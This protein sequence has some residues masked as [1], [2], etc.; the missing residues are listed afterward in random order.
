MGRAIAAALGLSGS[1]RHF[2][3]GREADGNLLCVTWCIGHLVQAAEPDAYDP[4]LKSWRLG[5]LPFL[6]EQFRYEAASSTGD[7][8]Q[9]VRELLQ[10]EDVTD[11]V[12]ATDAGRE[13]QLIFHLVYDLAGCARPVQRLWTSSLTDDAIR[14][15]W[16]AMKPDSA[17]RGLTDAAR[18]R[19]EADWLVGINCTRAQTLV[20]RSR[21][22][23]GVYSIGRVQTPTLAI[24][25]N[26]EKS[27]RD[28]VPQDFWTVL[29]TFQ[30]HER[31]ERYVGR[32]FKTLDGKDIERF[33]TEAEALTLAERLHGKAGRVTSVS[34]RAERRKAELLYDLTALQKEANRRFKWSAEHTLEV[35]QQLY[36]AKLLSYPRTS[37]RHLTGDDAK[38]APQWLAALDRAP[39]APFVSEIRAMG[40]GQA[41]A[42]SK[43]FVDDKQVEDHSALVVTEKA[44]PADLPSDQARLYDLVARRLLAAWFGDRVEHKTTILTVVEGESFKTTGAVLQDPGWTR[45]DPPPSRPKGDD[46]TEEAGLPLLKKGE[47]VAT[48]DIAP[49]AGKTSAPKPMTEADLLTAM[50]GAGKELDDEALRGAMKDSGLGTPATRANMIET[51]IKRAYVE[52][53][54]ERKN[55]VLQPTDK[56]IALI[57]SIQVEDLTSPVLTGR[58]EAAMEHIRRGEHERTQFMSDIRTFVAGLVQRIA[59]SDVRVGDAV[60][61][62][63]GAVLGT[64]T[65]CG[66]NLLHQHWQGQDYARCSAIREAKCRVSYAIHPDGRWQQRCPSCTGPLSGKGQCTWCGRG[67]EPS[68]VERPAPPPVMKCEGCRRVMRLV[69]SERNTQ[70]LLRCDPCGNWAALPR[71]ETVTP[72]PGVGACPKCQL[73]MAPMWSERKRL[74]YAACEPCGVASWVK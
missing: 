25:V 73:A 5:Q 29:A 61:K 66:S 3:Q 60:A 23:Q 40:K 70:W 51:L 74:W 15:A 2:I 52:R 21:G 53:K 45:V 59:A 16:K 33:D 37:S 13:G 11:V 46:E 71:P 58:W 6:P 7:Q 4:A 39:Y 9:A 56:G 31:N 10:R 22:G 67:G 1:G 26:R 69:W 49:K 32:W 27:I 20:A 35:A 30:P 50:Q 41:P 44:A 43:R 54:T 19:Q 55:T 34:G 36:E 14:A 62:G 38:K 12:N 64:C 65:R 28:F 48:V 8:W 24:L 47:A 18:C 63:P 72:Q 17:Y 42:L 57:D 68:A